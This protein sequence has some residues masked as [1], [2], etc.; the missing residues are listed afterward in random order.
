MWHEE[1]HKLFELLLNEVPREVEPRERVSFLNG[2]KKAD[3][4]SL[5][6]VRQ[7]SNRFMKYSDTSV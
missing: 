4:N 3:D 2:Q 6:Y 5:D 1:R 7:C